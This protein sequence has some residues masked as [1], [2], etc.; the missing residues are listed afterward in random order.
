MKL[1]RVLMAALVILLVIS[2]VRVHKERM[3][4][5]KR[6]DHST[7]GQCAAQGQ[8]GYHMFLGAEAHEADEGLRDVRKEAMLAEVFEK[9]EEMLNLNKVRSWF[10]TLIENLVG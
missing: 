1:N 6:L 10:S 2:S 7:G 3:K 5:K 9:I 8:L 4:E